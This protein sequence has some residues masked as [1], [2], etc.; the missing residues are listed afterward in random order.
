MSTQELLVAANKDE[1]KSV[2]DAASTTRSVKGKPKAS[3]EAK[4]EVS[5][6][7]NRKARR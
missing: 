4:D 1:G 3:A 2:P 5:T 6:G 7:S